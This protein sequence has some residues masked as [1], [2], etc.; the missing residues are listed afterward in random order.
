MTAE[1][2]GGMTNESEPDGRREALRHFRSIYIMLCPAALLHLS[3]AHLLIRIA[4]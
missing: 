1:H 2:S 4:Y 3:C